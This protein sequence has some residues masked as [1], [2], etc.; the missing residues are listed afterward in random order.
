MRLGR[1]SQRRRDTLATPRVLTTFDRLEGF[2]S[3][4]GARMPMGGEN[5][6]AFPFGQLA[7][8]GN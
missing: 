6:V 1:S 5:R 8:S 3:H 7:I 2:L 4:E